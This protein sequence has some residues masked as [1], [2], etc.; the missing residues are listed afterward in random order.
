MSKKDREKKTSQ[1]FDSGNKSDGGDAV[2][3]NLERRG[4]EEYKGK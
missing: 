4:N 1:G 2:T 3:E